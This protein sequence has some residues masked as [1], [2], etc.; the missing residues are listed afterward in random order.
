MLG[1]DYPKALVVASDFIVIGVFKRASWK[2]YPYSW[3]YLDNQY[4]WY[5]NGS[6]YHSPLS[7]YWVEPELMG[8]QVVNLLSDQI[9]DERHKP[10]CV[11]IP[12]T[13]E[14][15]GTTLIGCWDSSQATVLRLE[16]WSSFWYILSG[17]DLLNSGI[18]YWILLSYLGCALFICEISGS[19][20][21]PVDICVKNKRRNIKK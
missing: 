15:R 7:T 5:P 4:R 2:P 6:F 8:T 17:G 18:I 12:A 21:R 3:R 10:L 20:L 16:K 19:G 11:I 1:E 9:R 14:H 13:L